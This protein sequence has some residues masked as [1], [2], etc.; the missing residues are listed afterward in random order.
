MEV[1]FMKNTEKK[2]VDAKIMRLPAMR[3][4]S[5]THEGCQPVGDERMEEFVNWLKEKNLLCVPGMR[6][7]FMSYNEAKKGYELIMAIPEN[8]SDTGIYETRTLKEGLYAVTSAYSEEI[9]EKY[10]ELINWIKESE[11]YEIEAGRQTLGEVI[12]PWDLG[13]R[14]KF[15]QQ[16]IF[17]PIRLK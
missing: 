4:V 15:E 8:Y 13:E 9:E 1:V 2:F 6:Q 10:Y 16:D 5:S 12:T 3:V 11:Y 7:G 14:F 17:V